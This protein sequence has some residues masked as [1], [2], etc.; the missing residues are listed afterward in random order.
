MQTLLENI[1]H[2][3]EVRKSLI[4]MKSMLRGENAGRNRE[5]LIKLCAGDYSAFLM[6]L[7][8]SDAKVRKNA[9]LI[10]G[11]LAEPKLKEA[12]WA[13]YC[14]EKTRFVR[15]AYLEALK[16]YDYSDLLAGLKDILKQTEDI[17]TD[18]ENRKHLQEEKMLLR[19][20]IGAKEKSRP[21][22]YRGE[23]ILSEIALTTN[24]NHKHIVL[25]ALQGVRKKEF[26]AGVMVQTKYP[27]QLLSL[28]CFEEMFFLLPECRTV[29][30][31]PERAAQMLADAGLAEYLAE[32]HEEEERPFVFRIEIRSAMPL[33]KRAAFARKL[34]AALEEV[35][36]GRLVNATAG[37]EVEIRLI[38]AKNGDFNV[39]LKLLTLKDLRFAYRRKTVSTGMRPVNAALAIALAEQEKR[40][41]GTGIPFFKENARVLD[42]FCGS[43][44]MLIE[45]AKI[46]KV[47]E[48]YGLDILAEAIEAARFNTNLADCKANYVHRDFFTFTSD[49]RFDEI[50]T[51]MPFFT[52]ELPERKRENEQLYARF[53]E[54]IPKLMAE[55]GVMLLYTHNR[56][57]VKKYI[58]PEFAICREYELSM[59]EGCYLFLLERVE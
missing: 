27:M 19:E 25:D 13:A 55:D 45:R 43:G 16:K 29:N 12:L 57:L 28:R 26:N 4:E 14:D 48:M 5:R 50:I 36:G 49:I 6:L 3:M 41:K 9:A 35:S 47:K 54:K 21:H 15:S 1:Q 10:I 31:V 51:D 44:T 34:A 56:E 42:P 58:T 32:R 38:E 23:G 30:A 33:E 18:E 59:K 53:F 46:G 37:Y 52:S 20:L 22:I 40:G 24:R 11:E 2:N 17:K 7:K 39:L 8:D